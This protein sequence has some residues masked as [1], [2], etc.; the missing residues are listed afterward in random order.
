MSTFYSS[1]KKPKY[2]NPAFNNVAY[3]STGKYAV[4]CLCPGYTLFYMFHHQKL[5]NSEKV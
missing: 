1:N 3:I 2:I 4:H 5:Q